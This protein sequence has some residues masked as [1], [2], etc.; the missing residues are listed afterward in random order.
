M[1]I[2]DITNN[3]MRV[4]QTSP[5]AFKAY[6]T[7]QPDFPPFEGHFPDF[8]IMPGVAQISLI[9]AAMRK[10]FG[11]QVELN[12]IQRIKFTN[13]ALPEVEIVIT[14]QLAFA[15]DNSCTVQARL[16]GNEKVISTVKLLYGNVEV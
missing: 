6:F 15:E 12:S 7:P 4:E 2:F 8:K 9:T 10:I 5:D 13:P 11:E 3:N 1:D 14:A 16:S